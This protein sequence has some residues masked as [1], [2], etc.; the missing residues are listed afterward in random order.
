MYEKFKETAQHTLVF[1]MGGML[2]QALGYVLLPVYTRYLTPADYG[3]LNLL[4]IAGS[5]LS[6]MVVSSVGP[7]LFRSYYDYQSQRDRAMVVSTALFLS[8]GL[9]GILLILGFNLSRLLAVLL[10]GDSQWSGLIRLV[11]LTSMLNNMNVIALAVFRAQKWSGRYVL[12][13]MASMLIGG[14]ATGYLIVLRHLGI[15]GVIFG[16]LIGSLVSSIASLWLIRHHLCAAISMVEIGKMLRYGLPLVPENLLGFGLNSVDRLIIQHYLGPAAVG[17]YALGRRLGQ[18][19]QVLFV[20]PY[21]L[22]EGP[23]V[24]SM[25]NDVQAKKFYARLLTYYLCIGAFISIGVSLLARDVLRIMA[26][27]SYW[28]AST[29]VPWV[30]IGAVL[31]GLRGL[32]GVGLGLKRKTVWF[33]IALTIGGIVGVGLM[34][35]IVLPL[36]ING[37]AIAVAVSSLI[38]CLVRYWAGQRIYPIAFEGIRILKLVLVVAILL[39]IGAAMNIEWLGL[40]IAIRSLL[41]L[42]GMPV[43]LF[44]LSF[45]DSSELGHLQRVV[46]KVRNTLASYAVVHF[47]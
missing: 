17:L 6:A 43:L 39:I 18:I 3:V 46:M 23:V 40:S 28:S 10:T 13:S 34:F 21:S 14:G 16:S 25:E 33:P 24:L 41:V 7:A 38:T 27:A 45:F 22:I 44:S 11:L 20:Q 12:V 1:G 29:I 9:S 15:S 19:V 26:E 30:C 32:I 4:L 36:G 8:L 2:Q 37:I 42:L 47:S 5:L 31:Y 35:A